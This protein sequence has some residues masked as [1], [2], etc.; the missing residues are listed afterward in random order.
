MKTKFARSIAVALL[1][2]FFAQ[3]S[4]ATCGGGGGGGGGG[5][6]NNGGGGGGNAP[7]YHVPWKIR[8]PADPPATGLVLYWF[9]ASQNEI[10]SSSLR[11][12]RILSLYASQCVSMELAD[13]RI[14]H[15]DTLLGDSQLPV[16][17]L[18]KSDGSLIAKADRYR[19]ETA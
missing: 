5:M 15:A 17:A 14:P 7:V 10:K 4:F 3:S 12:S 2:L 9:P 13:S 19:D 6:S 1:A 16:V 8:K 18:A 11:E